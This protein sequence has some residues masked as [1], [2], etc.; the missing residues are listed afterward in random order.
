M[1]DLEKDCLVDSIGYQNYQEAS[2]FRNTEYLQKPIELIAGKSAF[3]TIN[4]NINIINFL[5]LVIPCFIA[6]ILTFIW[7]MIRI[8]EK[9]K[10]TNQ[11]INIVWFVIHQ[12]VMAILLMLASGLVWGYKYLSNQFEDVSISQLL[13]HM[14]TDLGG[15]NWSDFRNLFIEIGSSIIL[16]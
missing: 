4:A 7:N 8:V 2:V 14:T 5:Q 13:F 12:I 11:T 6:L 9:S 15:T 3:D 1:Y 16:L 10:R